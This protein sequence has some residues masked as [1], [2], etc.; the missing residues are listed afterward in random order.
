MIS[1]FPSGLAPGAARRQAAGL[2][3][4]F[5]STIY[6]GG[7]L[8]GD[9]HDHPAPLVLSALALGALMLLVT[10]LL[11]RRDAWWR[12]SLGLGRQPVGS[13]LGWSLLGFVGTYVMNLVLISAYL[14]AHG[15][16]EA[17]AAHR[18]TW[19]GSLAELPV[20][21]TLPL[22]AFAGVWEETV[23]R[24][25]LLGR[26][27]ASM[28]VRDSRGA[29]LHRDVLAVVLTGISWACR[30]STACSARYSLT[31]PRPTLRPTITAMITASDRS[32]TKNESVAVTIR[33][34]RSGLCS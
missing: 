2:L 32:P 7:I 29:A 30:A 4:L 6:G 31:K 18:A 21:V 27:R 15:N 26:L 8:V 33:S 3:V 14:A 1:P 13:M 25:F 28:P 11:V 24:G 17:V 19:L 9:I 16:L 23:F 34:S 12:E 5:F 22:V 10:V 20:E